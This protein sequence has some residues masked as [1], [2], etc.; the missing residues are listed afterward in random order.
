MMKTT[1]AFIFLNYSTNHL[2][3]MPQII[4]YNNS[5]TKASGQS[6]Q[7]ISLRKLCAITSTKYC[8]KIAAS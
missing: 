4:Y 6:K 8:T 2:F 3:Q 5:P 7:Y 1:I